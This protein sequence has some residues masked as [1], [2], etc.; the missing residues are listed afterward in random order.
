MLRLLHGTNYDFIK[1]WKHAAALTLAFLMIGFG[2]LFK[3]KADHGS[4]V[5]WNIEFTGGTFM[6]LKFATP[7]NP[8]D[9]RAATTAAG[10]NADVAQ[11]GT[12]TEYSI[13]AAVGPPPAVQV[14]QSQFVGPRVGAELKR[15]AT[16][17][18][19]I[20]FGVTLI[21]LAIRFEWRFGLAAV[22]ATAHDLLATLA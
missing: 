11:F 19:L 8:A 10:Y 3:H 21:Y 1:Y 2:L 12:P 4:A 14:V 6:Q 13:R 18:I 20:S 16:L 9:I 15:N 5:N 17:A 22:F 7:P